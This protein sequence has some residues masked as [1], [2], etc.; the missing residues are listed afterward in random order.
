ML[1]KELTDAR[2][3]FGKGHTAGGRVMNLSEPI[4]ISSVSELVAKVEEIRKREDERGNHVDLLFRGQP[5]DK[6]LLPSLGRLKVTRPLGS[7]LTL[8]YYPILWRY[9][10]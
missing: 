5:C 3:V 7:G 4:N 6:P 1:K 8:C 2:K 9:G 10:T